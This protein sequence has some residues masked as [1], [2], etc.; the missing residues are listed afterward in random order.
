MMYLTENH[1]PNEL[2]EFLCREYGA[3]SGGVELK[4]KIVRI[5][6]LIS[7]I[8]DAWNSC[9]NERGR[10]GEVKPEVEAL[11]YCKARKLAVVCGGNDGR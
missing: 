9:Q 11:I 8:V 1:Q 5:S 6:E 10:V 3:F 7:G 4:P 2:A